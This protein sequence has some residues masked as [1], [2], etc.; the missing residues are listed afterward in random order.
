MGIPTVCSY[1][2]SVGHVADELDAYQTDFILREIPSEL[3]IGSLQVI[4]LLS[5]QEVADVGHIVAIHDV[6]NELVDV[7]FV[8]TVEDDSLQFVKELLEVDT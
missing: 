5:G 2:S 8:A 3:P 4:L 1:K 7:D 6:I